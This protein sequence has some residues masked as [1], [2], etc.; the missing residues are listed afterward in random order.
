VLVTAKGRRLIAAAAPGHVTAVR[1]LFVDRLTPR[2]LDVV[3]SVAETVLAG[4]DEPVDT[5]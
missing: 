2:E 4:L 1:E 3:G 5:G